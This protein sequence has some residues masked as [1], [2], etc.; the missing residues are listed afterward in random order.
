MSISRRF[1]EAAVGSAAP[2]WLIVKVAQSAVSMALIAFAC[3]AVR[4]APDVG[5]TRVAAAESG[6]AAKAPIPNL[7]LVHELQT[8]GQIAAVTWSSDG[9]KLAASSIGP[10][11]VIPILP[12]M[13]VPN[14][15]GSLITIWDS[16]G[17]LYRQIKRPDPF[18]AYNDTFAFV[19]GDKQIATPPVSGGASAFSLFDIDTGE[20]VREIPGLYPD[21]PRNVNGAKA[22]ILNP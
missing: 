22:L 20:V 1:I 8:L 18:F 16:D 10:S 15:F 11:A 2:N 7:Q 14:A 4:A 5:I 19:A 9:T 21:K 3:C 12:P 17:H 13:Y 6:V